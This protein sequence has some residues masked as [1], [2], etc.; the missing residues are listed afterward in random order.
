MATTTNYGWG[1][2]TVGASE[3]I[4][5]T[6][7]NATLNAVD[8]QVKANADAVTAL[9]GP[10]SAFGRSLIDDASA[11]AAMTTLGITAFM[12]TLLDDTSAAAARA[13]LG[14]GTAAVQNIGTTGAAVP[15]LAG[16]ND[17]GNDGV[18]NVF[19]GFQTPITII[20]SNATPYQVAFA[21]G[22]SLRGYVGADV[23]RCIV[24]S[25][26]V[27]T[28]RMSVTQGGDGGVTGSWSVQTLKEI[29]LPPAPARS[30]VWRDITPMDFWAGHFLGIFT[31]SRAPMMKTTR[32]GIP[33][34]T[35]PKRRL[36][37][38]IVSMKIGMTSSVSSTQYMT[39][40]TTWDSGTTAIRP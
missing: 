31:S 11:G 20:N 33:R 18:A 13:T 17:W 26:S 7:L 22:A 1:L 6:I 35:I 38:P 25:D 39:S 34:A 15:L 9:V 3:D 40:I 36:S 23:T 14:L 4:W 37:F 24:A 5:G 21:N 2:P 8:V 19:R 30:Q 28:T 27:G 12:Q 32:I 10:V 16:N 29:R